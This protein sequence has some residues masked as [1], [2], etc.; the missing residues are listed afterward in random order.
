MIRAITSRAKELM[1][2]KVKR[3][4]KFWLRAFK[5]LESFHMSQ[6]AAAN[7]PTWITGDSTTPYSGIIIQAIA[8]PKIHMKVILLSCAELNILVSEGNPAFS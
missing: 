4:G 7:K 3:K 2:L 6:N 1:V 5:S 8:V